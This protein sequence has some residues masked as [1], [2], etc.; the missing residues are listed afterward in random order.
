KVGAVA[1]C[2]VLDGKITRGCQIRVIRDNIVIYESNLGSL[3]RFKDDVREVAS[4]FE[5]GIGVERFND[6][7]INDVIEGFIMEEIK[8]EL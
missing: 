8:R 7:E 2:Y 3:R 4:G 1:G 5:C 6:F